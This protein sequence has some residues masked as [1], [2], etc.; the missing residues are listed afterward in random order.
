MLLS[1][2]AHVVGFVMGWLSGK[3]T[4]FIERDPNTCTHSRKVIMT[5]RY[6]YLSGYDQHYTDT[7]QGIVIQ[8][9]DYA[10]VS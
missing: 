1:D 5:G 2:M 8:N 7:S 3:K 6:V 4:R 10:Y 9:Q